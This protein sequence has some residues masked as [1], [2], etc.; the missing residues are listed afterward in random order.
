MISIAPPVG[1]GGH[2]TGLL[3]RDGSLSRMTTLADRTRAGAGGVLVIRGGAGT[4]RTA[5]AGAFAHHETLRGTTVLGARCS[6]EEADASFGGVLQLF[7][8]DLLGLRDAPSTAGG[9]RWGGSLH[10]DDLPSLLWRLLRA[11]ASA[12]PVLLVVDDV[13]L[14][15]AHSLRWLAQ[16]ARRLDRLP[17]LLAVTERSGYDLVRPAPGFAQVVG[18]PRAHR[19]TLEPLGRAAVLSL[20]R[21]ALGEGAPLPL[22]ADCQRASGGNPMLLHALLCDLRAL[23]SDGADTSRLP[24]RC[25]E[26]HPGMF[27]DAVARWLRGCGPQA[28]S[29]IR[30]FAEIQDEDDAL[31]LLPQVTGCDPARVTG[32]AAGLVRQGLFRDGPV[33]GRP[34]FAHPLLRQAVVD[35]SHAHQRAEVHRRTAELLHHRGDPEAA[36]A[37]RLLL[38]PAVGAPWAAEALTGAAAEAVRDDRTDDAVAALRRALLEPLSTWR[39]GQVLTELGCLEFRTERA[40]GTRHLAEALRLQQNDGAKLRAATILGMAL[41]AGGAVHTALE[42]LGELSEALT[43]STDLSHAVQAATA[44]ISSHDGASW[45]Q[46]VARLKHLAE[47]TPGELAPTAAALLTEYEATAGQLSARDVMGRVRA[48]TAT[49]TD[50]HLEP[51]LLASAATLAQWADQLDEADRLVARGLAIHRSPLL[52]PGHQSLLSVRAES[53]VM[54]GQYDALLGDDSLYRAPTEARADLGPGNVHLRAQAVIALTETG[55]L[56]EAE[57]LC[58]A[59][60]SGGEHDCWEWSE[61]LYARGLLRLATR[62]PGDALADLL[63]C[64]RRQSARD[65][66]SPVVTPWRSAAA[67]CHVALGSAEHAVP[68]AEQELRLAEVWGTPRT[69]G[70]ALRALAA[71]VGGRR[72]L[73]LAGQAVDILRDA[74]EPMPELITALVSFGLALHDSGQYRQARETLREAAQQA[75]RLGAARAQLTVARALRRCGARAPRAPHTGASALTSCERRIAQLAAAG[76]SNKEAAKLLHLAVRTVETHLTHCYRKLGIRRRGDLAAALGT[77]PQFGA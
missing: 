46:V 26:L 20:V 67:D 44:M 47:H 52:H 36:V 8:G 51:Y 4:G 72:G 3:D 5:L 15:D 56:A 28:A 58:A 18:E 73:E 33:A 24:E 64:G 77:A 63:E 13:H 68:L 37:R 9:E 61:F 6:A 10:G 39:R 59:V 32:W 25:A 38:V 76:Y 70:R 22:A 50:P 31:A 7:E 27:A 62:N 12:G 2:V 65:S 57:R 29:A 21:T 75:E 23:S 71:S 43:Y 69:R 14:A 49:P 1:T 35:S 30:A 48:L 42:V 19:C 17:V 34:V 74:P 66:E 41:V 54:R 40:S 11:K 60:A 16:V 55:R 53:R 45:L